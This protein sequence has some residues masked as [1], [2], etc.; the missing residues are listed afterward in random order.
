MQNFA[1][2]FDLPNKHA[3]NYTLVH[4]KC[5][6]KPQAMLQ[7]KKIVCLLSKILYLSRVRFDFAQHEHLGPCL[8]AVSFGKLAFLLHVCWRGAQ[9]SAAKFWGQIQKA[10]SASFGWVSARTFSVDMTLPRRVQLIYKIRA[11]EC[12]QQ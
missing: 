2:I 1:C 12:L 5:A 9:V 8:R 6:F 4:S 7:A 3:E 10:P 11:E